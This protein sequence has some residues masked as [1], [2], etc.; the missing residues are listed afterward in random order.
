MKRK[1]PPWSAFLNLRVSIFLGLFSGSILL[2]LLVFGGSANDY[3]PGD[4]YKYSQ[5]SACP[6]RVLLVYADSIPPEILRTNLLADPDVTLVDLFDARTDT[7]ALSELQQYDIVY[8]YSN[9][10]Y[11]DGASLG[12]NLAD[13]QDG[14]GVVVAGYASFFGPPMSIEGRWHSDGYSPYVYTQSLISTVVILGAYNPRHPLMLGVNTLNAVSRIPVS[15][16][17]GATQVAAYSDASSAVAFKT[18]LGTTAVGMPA[19]MGDRNNNGSGQYA[20]IIANAGRWLHCGVTPTPTSTATES[21]TP[22]A[23]PT[24]TATSSGTPTPTAT[25]T[26]TFTPTATATST[27]TPTATPSGTPNGCIINGSI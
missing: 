22:T 11:A 15:V 1:S 3:G 8:A 2:A 6:L 7:P 10:P 21:V 17:A 24:P 13:Y 19:Y 14:G 25:S 4:D 27:A 20:T 16:A 26:P 9:D 5:A 18:N 23:T 12:D